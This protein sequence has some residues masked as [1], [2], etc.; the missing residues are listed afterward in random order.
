M[1]FEIL[2]FIRFGNIIMS[3]LHQYLIYIVLRQNTDNNTN[4]YYMCLSQL[5]SGIHI[6]V[7]NDIFDINTDKINRPN[8][9]LVK[10]KISVDIFY[11]IILTV[12]LCCILSIIFSFMVN[13]TIGFISLYGIICPFLYNYV[14]KQRHLF[15][16]KN[17]LV[18]LTLI[19]VTISPLLVINI[20]NKDLLLV[21]V[22]SFFSTYEREIIKDIE[23]IDGDKKTGKNTI[24]V[25][26]G[27]DISKKIIY[28]IIFNICM[29]T[30][31]FFYKS[32][33]NIEKII[34]FFLLITNFI[35]IYK[36]NKSHEKKH[37]TELSK[38]CKYQMLFGI[39]LLPFI[40]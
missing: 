14:Q 3:I 22:L 17:I 15:Y 40:S 2:K 24:P 21:S 7:M 5:F 6:Y 36:I 19:L 31:Y 9:F 18:S 37:Y 29:I 34:N 33:S 26:C 4:I 30:V 16:C 8:R 20:F 12:F 25:V 23:D 1:F 27:I 32:Y 38:L 39:V 10:N 35:F 11:L 13:K 28:T